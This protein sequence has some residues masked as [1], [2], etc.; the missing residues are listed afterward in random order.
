[1]ARHYGIRT[2]RYKLIRFYQFDEWEF[3]DLEKDPKENTNHYGNAKYADV[4]QQMKPRLEALRKQYKDDS[5]VS[6]MPV[7]WRKK[8]RTG[9]R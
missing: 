9:T 6:V 7:E 4:I 5:D 1:V 3:Y 8:F 2:A